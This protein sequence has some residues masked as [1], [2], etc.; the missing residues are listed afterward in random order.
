[1]TAAEFSRTVRVDTLGETPRDL[2][3]E[4]DEKERAA[5]ARRFGLPAIA[6]LSAGLALT[7]SGV[8]VTA[9]GRI[10]AEVT[11]SCVA[12]AEPVEAIVDEPFEIVFRPQPEA[13]AP[14]EEVELGESEMDV[15]FYDG[16]SIDIGE[17]VAETLALSLNPYP[18]TPGAEE[19]LR[20]AG[21]KSEEQAGPF[22]VLASLR[23]K[24][25][26]S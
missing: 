1:V 9:K 10:E 25:S 18:R 11:Q 26:K 17:A 6:A 13:S 23:D 3:I 14:D 4:A 15:V 24:L 5:L 2:S 12:T 7:R 8:E 16:A 21:V 20:R 19:I 22:G